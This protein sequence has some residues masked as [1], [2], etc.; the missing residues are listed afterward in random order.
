MNLLIKRLGL[1]KRRTRDTGGIFLLIKN[2][3]F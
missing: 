2:H 1:N 3:R